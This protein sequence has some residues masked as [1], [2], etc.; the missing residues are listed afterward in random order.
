M[1]AR[2][3]AAATL[4]DVARLAGVSLP[5]ASYALRG[6]RKVSAPVRQRVAAA[7]AQLGYRPHSAARA[8]ARGRFGAVTL[9]Q[10]AYMRHSFINAQLLAGI[11]EALERHELSLNLVRLTREQMSSQ[12]ILPRELRELCTDGLLVNVNTAPPRAMSAVLRRARIPAIWLNIRRS[13]DCV[14]PDDFGGSGLLVRELLKVGARR[15][16]YFDSVAGESDEHYSRRDRYM[17]YLAAMRQEGL[18]PLS[19]RV[20]AGAGLGRAADA[21]LRWLR[22]GEPLDAL[23]T[24]AETELDLYVHYVQPGLAGR[25]QPRLAS[26]FNAH[27]R[28]V[29]PALRAQHPWLELGRQAVEC[30]LLKVRNPARRIKPRSVPFEIANPIELACERTR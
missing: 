4:K 21:M 20:R 7:A 9:L 23:M 3:P 18:A 14:H 10:D 6:M 17:G 19:L 26:F 2:I 28:M 8:M 11:Q 15:I 30:L 1:I 22:D 16:G 12:A 25:R 24:Y 27:Q 5:A 13:C 29:M